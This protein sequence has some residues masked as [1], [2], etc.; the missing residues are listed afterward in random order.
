MELTK[1]NYYSHDADAL[2]YSASQIKG[3]FDCEA[4]E[5]A[6]INELYQEE[7]STALMA[8]SYVDAYFEGSAEQFQAE[9]P[10]IFNKRTG[11]LKADY[12]KADEMIQR[13]LQDDVF[14]EYMRGEKQKI[15]TGTI[16]GLPF[17]A[18]LDVYLEHERIVDLKT[19]R[20][21]GSQY[22]PGQ[23]RLRFD[24]VFHYPLQLAIYQELVYQNT[25]EKLPCFIAC[26][27]K[28]DPPDI[29][30]FEYPQAE[31]DT[32]MELLRERLPRIDAIKSGVLDPKRCGK[33][34][35][36]RATNKL[37]GPKYISILE[38]IE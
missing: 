22:A 28:E 29:G 2:Y 10:E 17:K 27:T 11:E 37:A 8:G 1:E 15:F 21:F 32:E 18:K 36:C 31:L 7:P 16:A 26:I 30:L 38:E 9:H 20:D 35:Y 12:K 24:E 14:K 23:G 5:M 6:R 4:R 34:R 33:C 25:G 3:F 13:A 19:C